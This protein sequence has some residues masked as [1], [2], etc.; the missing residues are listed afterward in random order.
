[1]FCA[2]VNFLILPRHRKIASSLDHS[3]D[4]YLCMDSEDPT[5]TSQLRSSVARRTSFDGNRELNPDVGL[6]DTI[7]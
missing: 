1:M 5:T 7:A 4:E 3:N 2:I 6:Y